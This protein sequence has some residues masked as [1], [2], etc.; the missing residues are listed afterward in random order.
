MKDWKKDI[1]SEG[2]DSILLQFSKK[3]IIIEYVETLERNIF[4]G[5]GKFYDE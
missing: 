3:V 2:L 5:I 1:K 4:F